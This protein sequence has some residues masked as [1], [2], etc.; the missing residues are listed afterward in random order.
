MM[1]VVLVGGLVGLFIGDWLY[2]LVKGDSIGFG[3]L[4]GPRKRRGP[5]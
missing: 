4:F 5:Q 2:W 3:Y 1:A